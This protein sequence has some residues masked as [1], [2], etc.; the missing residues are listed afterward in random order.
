MNEKEEE[1]E[2]KM[3]GKKMKEKN[4]MGLKVTQNTNLIGFNILKLVS[5]VGL[6]SGLRHIL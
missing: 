4:I 5:E 6:Q 3:K 1:M 2:N